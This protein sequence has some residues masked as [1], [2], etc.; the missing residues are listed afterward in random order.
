MEDLKTC[1]TCKGS[2]IV[3]PDADGYDGCK[4]CNYGDGPTGYEPR[5]TTDGLLDRR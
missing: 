5:A 3:A 2:G 4:A 1:E